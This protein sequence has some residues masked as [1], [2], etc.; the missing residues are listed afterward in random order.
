MDMKNRE[1]LKETAA[2]LKNSFLYSVTLSILLPFLLWVWKPDIKVPLGILVSITAFMF[3][4]ISLLATA[5]NILMEKYKAEKQKNTDFPKV[6]KVREVDNSIFLVLNKSALFNFNIYTSVYLSDENS[7]E[8]FIGVGV[9]HNIQENGLIQVEILYLEESH[10]TE[11]ENLKQNH[12][13]FLSKTVVKPYITDIKI[14]QH[15]GGIFSV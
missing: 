5:V 10:S 2:T 12:N 11:W 4:L 13:N 9:V 8:V 1:L 14:R 7:S 15:L 3:L 6:I